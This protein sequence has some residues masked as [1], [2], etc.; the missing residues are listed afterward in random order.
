MSVGLWSAAL[1]VRDGLLEAGLDLPKT[2]PWR[3]TTHT[4]RSLLT[5]GRPS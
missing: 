5:S 2:H 3:G 1:R 4:L